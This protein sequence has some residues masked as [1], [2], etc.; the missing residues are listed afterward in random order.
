VGNGERNTWLYR[1]VNGG[2]SLKFNPEA[3]KGILTLKLRDLQAKR[4]G[5]VEA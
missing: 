2:R 5:L 3:G 1:R 4:S